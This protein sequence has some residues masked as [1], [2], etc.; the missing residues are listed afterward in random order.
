MP[1]QHSVK[2]G[3]VERLAEKI[4][5]AGRQA[6]LTVFGKGIGGEGNDGDLAAGIAQRRVASRPSISGIC[7]SMM[8]RS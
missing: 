3:R 4:V 2:V 8:I 5:H 7:R 1:T 6:A